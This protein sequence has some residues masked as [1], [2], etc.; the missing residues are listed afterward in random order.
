MSVL[1]LSNSQVTIC[2][3]AFDTGFGRSTPQAK[4]ERRHHE[5]NLSMRFIL[6][7]QINL[8]MQSLE[9]DADTYI[10][11]DHDLELSGCCT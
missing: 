5:F 3:N 8:G 11:H 7:F 10:T 1:S 2:N 6:L 4:R 9:T